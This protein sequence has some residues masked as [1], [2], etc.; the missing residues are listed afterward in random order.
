MKM[1]KIYTLLLSLML[2]GIVSG[3][4]KATH[5]IGIS[6]GVSAPLGVYASTD[7]GAFGTWNNFSGFAKTGFNIGLDGAYHFL[8]NIGVGGSI[9]FSDHGRL[10]GADVQKLAD[11]Y[12]DAFA[13][14]YSTVRTQGRYQT[15]NLF[16]GPCFSLPLKKFTFEARILGG[17]TQN[18]SSPEIYVTLEDNPNG[19]KQKSSS[20]NAFGWQTGLGIRYA[21]TEKIS[22]TMRGDY[23]HT[24]GITIDNENRNNAAGREVTKQRMSWTNLSLGLAYAFGK[25]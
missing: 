18:I 9:N 14:D 7:A 6:G 4:Q 10:S 20:H 25:Q 13:V 5:Y 21:L 22:F 15:L 19:F 24:N 2:A 12:T 8:P 17:L 3:Q 1:K 23:F 16:A 11:S